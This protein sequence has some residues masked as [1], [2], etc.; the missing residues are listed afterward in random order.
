MVLRRTLYGMVAVGAADALSQA[1]PW[2]MNMSLVCASRA[3]MPQNPA[4]PVLGFRTLYAAA[5]CS[6]PLCGTSGQ[7]IAGQTGTANPTGSLCRS[8]R[9]TYYLSGCSVIRSSIFVMWTRS[10][11]L[12]N[13]GPVPLTPI[14][15]V[16]AI[17]GTAIPD[18]REEARAT[19]RPFVPAI[20][21]VRDVPNLKPLPLSAQTRVGSNYIHALDGFTGSLPWVIRPTV[22]VIDVPITGQPSVRRRVLAA[23]IPVAVPRAVP[24]RQETKIRPTGRAAALFRGASL[25]SE[26]SDFVEVLYRS[27]P[28]A[29]RGGYVSLYEKARYVSAHWQELDWQTVLLAFAANELGDTVRGAQRGLAGEISMG[30]DPSGW[31]YRSVQSAGGLTG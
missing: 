9:W 18:P 22:T 20:P 28:G 19:T 12:A 3:P 11:A 5:S 17:P 1:W 29:P 14:A 24:L 15:A 25:Y 26:A 30:A 4:C 27:L 21:A 8:F 16:P 2:G 10:G 7:S 31:L 6:T 23:P 13:R